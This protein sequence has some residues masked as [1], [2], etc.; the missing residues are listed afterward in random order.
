MSPGPSPT[1]NRTKCDPRLH[2]YVI[3]YNQNVHIVLVFVC[4][5]YF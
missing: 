3:E 5:D 4:M 1:L 2:F